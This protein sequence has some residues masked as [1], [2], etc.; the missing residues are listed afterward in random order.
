MSAK[1]KILLIDDDEDYRASTLSLLVGEGYL[2]VEA[3]SGQEGLAAVRKHRP[4]LVI[5]DV[6]MESL[7]AGYSFTQAVKFGRDYQDLS[8]TPILMISSVEEDPASMYSWIGDASRITPDAYLAKPLDVARFL[9]CVRELLQ[10]RN[11]RPA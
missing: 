10:R 7:V 8:Q 4:D 5:V 2:V 11:N 9:E 6:M 1:A 3:S